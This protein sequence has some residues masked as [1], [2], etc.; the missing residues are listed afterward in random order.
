M[1]PKLPE[2]VQPRFWIMMENPW[3]GSAEFKRW[4]TQVIQVPAG[5]TRGRQESVPVI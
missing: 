3:A 4:F 1:R 5:D 2:I